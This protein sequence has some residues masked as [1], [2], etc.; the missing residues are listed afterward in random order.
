MAG[1]Y[2]LFETNKELETEGLVLDYGDFS[3]RIARAGGA[4]K[5]F[6]KAMVRR[7]K[8]F[9]RAIDTETI[10][11][12]NATDILRA[13]Y[14]ET[15]V[16]GWEGVTDREGVDLEFSFQNIMQLFRDLP[17]LF[18]DVQEQANKASLFH[19]EVLGSSSEN[20]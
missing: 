16:L 10:D 13:V 11:Q 1:A 6:T 14:A 12:E 7:T 9:R 4:N 3:I 19:A 17:D 15:V 8:P 20:S 18:I 2:E 5:R